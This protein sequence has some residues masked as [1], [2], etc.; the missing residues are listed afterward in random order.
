[1]VDVLSDD[2]EDDT[3]A[4]PMPNRRRSVSKKAQARTAGSKRKNAHVVPIPLCFKEAEGGYQKYKLPAAKRVY[5]RREYSYTDEDKVGTIVP[6]KPDPPKLFCDKFIFTPAR[7]YMSQAPQTVVGMT[8]RLKLL[9]HIE[10]RIVRYTFN[11][12]MFMKLEVSKEGEPLKL[13]DTANERIK[14]IF[15]QAEPREPL[16]PTIEPW[17]EKELMAW[18]WPELELTDGSDAFMHYSRADV[19]AAYSRDTHR[20]LSI[21]FLSALGNASGSA[22]PVSLFKQTFNVDNR[23]EQLQGT[24]RDAVYLLSTIVREGL[25]EQ[26]EGGPWQVRDRLD[27]LFD[28]HTAKHGKGAPNGSLETYAAGDPVNITLHA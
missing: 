13:L 10:V 22:Q 5:R 21:V 6:A 23:F 24:L 14:T 4:V 18:A 28:V 8:K 26:Q 9:R 20:V 17:G 7:T 19:V 25:F 11:F 2:D 27:I 1:M 3:G 12:F 15:P 16:T